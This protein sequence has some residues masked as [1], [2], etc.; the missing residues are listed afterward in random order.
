MEDDLLKGDNLLRDKLLEKSMCTFKE[1]LFKEL[2][3][4]RGINLLRELESE[5][6][7]HE[8]T[9]A[10]IK[11]IAVNKGRIK[12]EEFL[13]LAK[14]TNYSEGGWEQKILPDLIIVGEGWY[15]SRFYDEECD[16]EGFEFHEIPTEY[17]K[18]KSLICGGKNE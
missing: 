3:S 6:E 12:I 13:E 1:E 4:F 17:I 10:D 7:C 8:K 18:I 5:L 15:I 14:N 9:L 2:G 16:V 11:W